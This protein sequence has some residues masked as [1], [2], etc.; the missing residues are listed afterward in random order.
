MSEV[1][2]ARALAAGFR[3]VA[4]LLEAD[5]EATAWIVVGALRAAGDMRNGTTA[6][7]SVLNQLDVVITDRDGTL[8]QPNRAYAKG[9]GTP[10]CRC[11]Y[12][13]SDQ[14]DL[15]EH[16]AAV[17]AANDPAA[18]ATEPRGEGQL[19][20]REQ[21]AGFRVAAAVLESGREAATLAT[22]PRGEDHMTEADYQTWGRL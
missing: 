22:E 10:M 9:T 12:E 11:G 16:V 20:V 8:H 17:L 15:D 14:T 2:N 13:A 7:A 4:E 1:M 3:V 19:T 18:L 6:F 5:K 21:A